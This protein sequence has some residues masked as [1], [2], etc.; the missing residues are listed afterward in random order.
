MEIMCVRV[1]VYVCV[2]CECMYV[3]SRMRK[4]VHVQCEHVH[5]WAS[6]HG[7]TYA[8]AHVSRSICEYVSVWLWTCLCAVCTHVH[9]C[10]H[11]HEKTYVCT[12]V[13]TDTLTQIR[14]HVCVWRWTTETESRFYNEEFI[15]PHQVSEYDTSLMPKSTIINYSPHGPF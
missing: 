6:V 7:R 2:L 9:V 3:H 14:M 10:V 1:H 15:L 11:S 13:G 5:L 12:C 4:C 8:W